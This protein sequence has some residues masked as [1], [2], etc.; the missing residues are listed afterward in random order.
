MNVGELIKELKP[1]KDRLLETHA[2]L[3]KEHKMV[4]IG[5]IFDRD[6]YV[7]D[8]IKELKQFD[9]EDKVEFDI[10]DGFI[11]RDLTG[12]EIINDEVHLKY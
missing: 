10:E 11:F 12:I 1:H 2:E 7:K 6:M 9:L 4:S 3:F 8:F 5:W